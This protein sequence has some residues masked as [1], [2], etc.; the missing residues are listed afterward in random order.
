M[1][2][3]S[4]REILKQIGAAATALLLTARPGFSFADLLGTGE[5]FEMLVVGDS[6]IAGQGLREEDKFY[7]LTRAWLENEFFDGNRNVILK[8]KSHS[9]AQIFL[10]DSQKNALVKAERDFDK[11]FH[12]E[13]SFSSPS[14]NTQVEIAKD[15]Y[16]EE[17]K[18]PESVNLVMLT[19]GITNVETD[20]IADPYKN[21][22]PLRRK[23]KKYC[24]DEMFRFLASAAKTF[25]N[26]LFAVIGYYPMVSSKSSTGAILNAVLELYKY[27]GPTKP[28]VNNIVTKQV[29][30]ILHARMNKR[31]RIWAAESDRG[32]QNAVGRLNR[33]HGRTRAIFIKSP[34]DGETTF[35]TKNTLVWRMGKKGR[36][37][38]AMYDIRKAECEKVSQSI[39]GI[40]FDFRQ[41]FCELSGIGHPNVD[42]SKA[43]AEAIRMSLTENSQLLVSSPVLAKPRVI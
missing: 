8:N 19:G 9:G 25:P 27:P 16:L 7:N 35:E 28:I 3:L 4:R 12:P 22:S 36:S 2:D 37:E 31:S 23:I 40:P 29:F 24:D 43:Y 10:S 18:T 5:D 14:M 34:I 11:S 20:Y 30:K 39:S 1:K 33:D 15:E 13:V 17:G 42:G 38:D 26:A 21:Y 41:R 32:Y 6:L